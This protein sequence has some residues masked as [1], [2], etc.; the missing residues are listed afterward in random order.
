M[1]KFGDKDIPSLFYGSV[2]VIKAYYGTEQV[3]PSQPQYIPVEWIETDGVTSYLDTGVAPIYRVG[4]GTNVVSEVTLDFR[5]MTLPQASNKV[6]LCGCRFDTATRGI[7]FVITNNTSSNRN[8]LNTYR[9]TVSGA[10]SV[11]EN[12]MNRHSITM[13]YPTITM[14]GV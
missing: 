14:D 13:A 4:S 9:P 5:L 3:W 6:A 11:I 10:N 12:D 8:R 1:L 2:P 7:M